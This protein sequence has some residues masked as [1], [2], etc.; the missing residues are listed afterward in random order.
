MPA[1][2]ITLP[3]QDFFAVSEGYIKLNLKS[4]EGIEVFYAAWRWMVS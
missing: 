3:I 2:K 1:G 4:N